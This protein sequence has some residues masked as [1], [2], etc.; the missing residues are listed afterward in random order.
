[1]PDLIVGVRSYFLY[2]KASTR[3]TRD[4]Q[5]IRYLQ[6]AHNEWDPAA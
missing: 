1:M 6:L 4:G 2:V 3:K 5:T